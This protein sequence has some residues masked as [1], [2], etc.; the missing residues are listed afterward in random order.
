LRVSF[1]SRA[2]SAAL[3]LGIALT[4]TA[5]GSSDPTTETAEKAAASAPAAEP[6]PEAPTGPKVAEPTVAPAPIATGIEYLY[7]QE[8][9]D[10]AYRELVE[11]AT[12]HAVNPDYFFLDGDN[13]S[14]D[15]DP[16]TGRFDAETAR[17]IREDAEGCLAADEQSCADING[18]VWFDN[19]TPERPYTFR[20]DMEF[21]TEQSITNP[22]AVGVIPDL[23]TSHL[24]VS[25]DHVVRVRFVIDGTPVQATLTRNLTYS[26]VPATGAGPTSWLITGWQV[27]FTPVIKDE[28][29]GQPLEG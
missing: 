4:A 23:G 8:S 16:I 2:L 27:Q 25:F 15:L 28:A 17:I 6:T 24:E 13:S 7:G 3:A 9:V 5:C 21:V 26:L 29:T 19:G 18:I 14:A 22:K 11:L 20:D 12:V 1:T 10:V